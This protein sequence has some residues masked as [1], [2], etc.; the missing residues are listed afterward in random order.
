MMTRLRSKTEV[1]S[2]LRR[3]GIPDAR[4][5]EILTG[6]QDPIDLDR[7][8]VTLERYG[9]SYGNLIDMIGGSP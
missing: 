9:L 5:V 1:R 6:L 8:Q 3:V 4:I 2:V 7:D